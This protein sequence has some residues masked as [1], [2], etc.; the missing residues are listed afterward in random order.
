M[1]FTEYTYKRVDLEQ[2][3]EDF[4]VQLEAME[5][6]T[7]LAGM[8]QAI[9]QIYDIRNKFETMATLASVRYS[10][11]MNDD[12]YSDENAFYDEA[13]PVMEGL[14]SKFYDKLVGSPL[15]KEI[16]AKYGSHLMNIA[17][18]T[19]KTFAD[20]ILEDLQEENKTTT[21]YSLLVGNAQ[22]HFRGETYN[23]SRMSPFLHSQDRATRIEA[24]NA[25]TE[26][27]VANEATIDALYD[28]LVKIRHGMAIKLGYDNYVQL[29]YDKLSRTDYGPKEVAK[30]RDQVLKY[31]VPLNRSL[32]KRQTKRLG[33]NHLYYYDGP[34][35][36]NS[37]N[38]KP[39]GDEAWMV[40][41]AK[42]MYKELSAETDDF[43]TFMTEKNLLDLTSKDGK[44]QG[45]Y[46]TYMPDYRSPFI[47]ANF[48][49]TAHDVTVLTHEAGHAFQI[50][51]SRDYEVSEYQWP[52]LEACE[53][54]SMSMEYL[55]YPWM[56]NFFGEDHDK[57]TFSHSSQPITFIPYGVTVDEFQHWVYE[58]PEATPDERKGAWRTIEKTYL[59]DKDYGDNDFL[60][61]GGFW[62]RQGHIFRSPF[63]YIDYTLA[64]TCAAQFYVKSLEDRDKAWQDYVDLCKAGGSMPFTELL[65]VADV[66]SPFEEGTLAGVADRIQSLL[67]SIDDTKL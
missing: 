67:D 56:A 10:I 20:D 59:P 64:M 44:R 30:F 16:E 35:K 43:F 3:Q 14:V 47:F 6:A 18:L 42:H 15:S 32:V 51:S 21:E 9:K 54:H 4:Q 17:K 50:Y 27:W 46:C 66:K 23:M 7:D 55:T 11:D 62:F 45:G 31:I 12:F 24:Q 34:F 58:H 60:E 61:K 53:I 37:G 25:V 48:N 49:G 38:P 33:L 5:V 22:I 13:Q 29:G 19:V 8:D 1:N 39:A 41:Q 26:F 36:F 63:Y 52:T 65:K 57:F 2:I 28:K 40:E